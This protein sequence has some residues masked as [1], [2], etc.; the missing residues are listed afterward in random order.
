MCL[1]FAAGLGGI[2]PSFAQS[3]SP[4]GPTEPAFADKEGKELHAFHIIGSAPKVDGRLDDEAWTLA[5][6][7]SGFTQI[8][9]DNMAP[10]TERT[11]VQVA[12]DN[13]Y[14]YVAV[15]CLFKNPADVAT[16]L[17]RRDNIPR[18]DRTEHQ[19][20]SPARSSDRLHVPGECVGR[21]GGFHVLRRQP[22]QLRL[23]RRVGCLGAGASRRME[24]RAAN[25]V[26][27]AALQRAAGRERRS[28]AST[29]SA[30]MRRRA[31]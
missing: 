29:W 3:V 11:T 21:P 28:G 7:I 15:H 24:R 6:T 18:S 19:L 27:P 9:P 2:S 25:S 16:G 22:H 13:R 8:D 30:R 5:D 12:F 10:A 4:A 26:L 14:V 23:R 20:R 1:S 31:R 17:G